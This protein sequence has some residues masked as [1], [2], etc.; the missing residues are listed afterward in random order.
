V[1]TETSGAAPTLTLAR[2]AYD[3]LLTHARERRPREVC[4]VLGGRH[5]GADAGRDGLVT[6]YRPVENAAADPRTTYRMDPADLLAALEAVEAEADVVGFAH[7]H[8]RGPSDPSPTDRARATWPGHVYA[9]VDLGGEHPDV[10]AWR[11]TGD[12]FARVA[13]AVRP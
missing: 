6:R 4:G 12:R 1:T 8:P 7:S 13:V 10:G 11:W 9:I 2:T 3:R 5:G